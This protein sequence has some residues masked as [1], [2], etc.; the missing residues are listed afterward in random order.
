V[1]VLLDEDLPRQLKHE[2]AGHKVATVREMRWNGILNGDLLRLASSRFDVFLTGDRN[3]QY[4]QNL[5]DIG[6][7]LVVLAVPRNNMV[8]I[9][10]IVPEILSAL[11]GSLEPG[12]AKVVG[13]WRVR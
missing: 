2:I 13:S 7:A 12:T 3:M 5:A 10:P 8:A 1:R 6:I 9:R 11:S 4:Q